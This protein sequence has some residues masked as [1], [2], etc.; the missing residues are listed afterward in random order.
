MAALAKKGNPTA[1]ADAVKQGIEE[2]AP[3]LSVIEQKLS[4]SPYVVGS[5]PTAADLLCY[6]EFGQLPELHMY[7]FKG[8]PNIAAWIARMQKY[9]GYQENAKGVIAL[10]GIFKARASKM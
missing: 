9:P 7:D 8:Y 5:S 1:F 2:V 6:V 10:A 4:K 3:V